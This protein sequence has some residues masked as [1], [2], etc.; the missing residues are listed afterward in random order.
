ME[1]CQIFENNRSSPIVLEKNN[2]VLTK[3]QAANH[4]A[5]QFSQVSNISVC[6]QRRQKLRQEITERKRITQQHTD[7]IMTCPF[8]MEE[9]E[10][11]LKGM[12]NGRSPGPDNITNDMLAHLGMQAKKKLLGLFNTSWKTGLIPS[13]WKK[14][15]LIPILKAGKPRNKGNSYR[16]ISLTSCMCKL[17]E[18]MVNKRLMWYLE[19]NKILM[20]EQAGFRQFRSTEDQIA[21][22]AQTIE[23]GY[24]RQQHTA[25]V[26]VD[27]EKAFDKV[28][29]KGLVLQLMQAGVSHNMLKWIE[30]Y[31]IQRT[32]RVSLQGKESRQADF[33]D[34]VPQGG[35]LSSTLFLVF[36][37]S[38]QNI[39]KPHVKAA[40]YA[41]D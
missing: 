13:I 39:I 1:T 35:V 4:L 29:K 14:A 27:M 23:D 5:K 9:L 20:D 24:Q 34:G 6:N 19:R 33:K 18:R 30:K 8:V 37:N 10:G 31:L 17:M 16:P 21:Y 40:L 26:W 11:A 38:I 3:K 28:W 22:I 2:R 25:T 41:D 7:E 36:M 15:I 12:Q 32:G